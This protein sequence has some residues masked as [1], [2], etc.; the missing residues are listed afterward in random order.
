M[1]E[2]PLFNYEL[3][4]EEKG[5]VPI[6]LPAPPSRVN[7]NA[8][9]WHEAKRDYYLKLMSRFVDRGIQDK[10]SGMANPQIQEMRR[11]EI[12]RL[13]AMRGQAEQAIL[14]IEGGDR[15]E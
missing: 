1:L 14:L 6:A 5:E 8:L 2:L 13:Q 11:L 3:T 10:L 4:P 9:D 7:Q 15:S 12:R